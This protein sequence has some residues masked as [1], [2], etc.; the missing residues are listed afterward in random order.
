[1]SKRTLALIVVL[2]VITGAL[3]IV[4]LSSQQHAPQ[5]T[6]STTT[7]IA[8]TNS[9][10]HTMLNITQSAAATGTKG[11]TLDVLV[12][13]DTDKSTGVQLE[14]QYDPNVIT[15]V[16]LTP[17][18]FYSDPFVLINNIDKKNGRISYAVAIKPNGTAQSGKGVVAI[19][20]YDLAAGAS[21]NQVAFTFLPKSKAT[22][23]G[24]AQSV[25][26][27]T[28]DYKMSTSAPSSQTT[29]GQG[30]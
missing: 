5:A 3:L 14:L 2:A 10:A 27:G 19:I 21:A 22:A 18:T 25:L 23:E 11:Q 30:Y 26:K 16:S 28:T 24:V 7:S 9:P 8:P 12:D 4:A 20:H 29:Q 13:T 6:P 15:N 17:G 1:M